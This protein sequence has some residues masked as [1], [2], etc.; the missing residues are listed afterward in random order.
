MFK[1]AV[2]ILHAPGLAGFPHTKA[3]MNLWTPIEIC[4]Y[5]ATWL[6]Q[7]LDRRKSYLEKREFGANLKSGR[8]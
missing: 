4:R 5:C 1:A 3:T 2:R 6:P 7:V 8:I